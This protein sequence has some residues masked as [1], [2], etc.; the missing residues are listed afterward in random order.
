V[1]NGP[2]PQAALCGFAGGESGFFQ[3]PTWGSKGAIPR[4]MVLR[5]SLW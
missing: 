2:K 3:I 1:F 4:S 5:H